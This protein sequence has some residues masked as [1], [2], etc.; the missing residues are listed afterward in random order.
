MCM[1]AYISFFSFA[2]FAWCQK[3]DSTIEFEIRGICKKRNAV[4][5]SLSTKDYPQAEENFVVEKC[6]KVLCISGALFS[7]TIF[8]KK[9]NYHCLVGLSS[10]QIL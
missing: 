9:G 10:K 7:L 1:S 8:L 6:L 4:F 5:Q 3:W 2:G